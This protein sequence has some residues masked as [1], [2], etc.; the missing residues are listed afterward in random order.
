MPIIE[1]SLQYIKEE[2]K[3]MKK[4][5]LVLFLFLSTTIL[6]AGFFS[7]MFGSV[8]A[9]AITAPSGS[10]GV[11]PSRYKQINSYIWDMHQ[12]KKYNEDYLYYTEILTG[13]SDIDHL[14]T[15]AWAYYDNGNAKKA[16]EIYEN[17]ILPWLKFESYS[18]RTNFENN[19]KRFTGV[20]KPVDYQKLI[21]KLEK[22]KHEKTDL[23][24]TIEKMDAKNQTQMQMYKNYL[25][26]IL[27]V[28]VLILILI[29]LGFLMKKEKK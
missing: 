17:K 4:L 25:M 23:Q 2:N 6:N 7:S 22:K 16:I 27:I 13:S 1:H 29:A 12:A 11:T 15:A 28:V 21:L 3:I 9:N 20:D 5:L 14:D 18:K 19:Y 26:A 10:H 8:A 24:K